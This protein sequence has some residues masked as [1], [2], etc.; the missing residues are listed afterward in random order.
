MKKNNFEPV[1]RI[2]WG[3]FILC[4]V[5]IAALIKIYLFD[6]ATESEWWF[7]IYSLPLL[8]PVLL[9]LIFLYNAKRAYAEGQKDLMHG[10]AF[11]NWKYDDVTWTRFNEREWKKSRIKAVGI[12]MA[13]LL[14]LA[15]FGL[16]DPGF[17]AEDFGLAAPFVLI[18]F[19]GLSIVF[20]F[21]TYALYHRT[22]TCPREVIIGEGGILYGGYY[23]SWELLTTRLAGVKYIPGEIP[24]LE[25]DVKIMGKGGSNSHP[26]RIP[27]PAG[28]EFEAQELITKFPSEKKEL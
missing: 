13:F 27:V 21:Y 2:T 3:I 26:I 11:A 28:K 15:L 23:N 17:S 16:L 9:F 8:I 1:I 12:P 20:L 6:N 19:G 5:A 10:K 14:V 25:F 24:M 7:L 22:K 18:F 4:L